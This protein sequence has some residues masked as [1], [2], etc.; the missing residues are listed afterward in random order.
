MSKTNYLETQLLNH[1][2]RNVSYP[3]PT[4][5]YVALFTVSPSEG[6]GGVEVSGG[7][8]VRQPVTFTVPA[9]DSVT[10]VSDVTFPIAT[11]DWGT[12]VAFAIM[13]QASSGNML[14]YANLTASRTILASDQLRFPSAQL[15]ISEQ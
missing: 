6:G 4:S 3:S 10:N 12:V 5:I 2:L 11:V 1:V 8:Y 15:I 13:D 7:G 9:P 14:Y